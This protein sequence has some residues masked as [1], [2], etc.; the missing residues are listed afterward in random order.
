MKNNLHMH[1]PGFNE[2]SAFFCIPTSTKAYQHGAHRFSN[3]IHILASFCIF[4]QV[5]DGW[6]DP[7]N[8]PAISKLPPSNYS[9]QPYENHCAQILSKLQ[10]RTRWTVVAARDRNLPSQRNFRPDRKRR[11]FPRLCYWQPL[12]FLRSICLFGKTKISFFVQRSFFF[13]FFSEKSMFEMKIERYRP[14]YFG[15]WKYYREIEIRK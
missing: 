10:S 13:F 14:I 9:S 4:A 12:R 6:S 3:R 7:L 15:S 11:S 8:S 1:I 5:S 2:P